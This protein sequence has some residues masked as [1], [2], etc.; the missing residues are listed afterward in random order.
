[1]TLLKKMWENWSKKD[2]NSNNFS[3][4]LKKFLN[5]RLTEVPCRIGKE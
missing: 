4:V 5:K 3:Q 2:L 1:M